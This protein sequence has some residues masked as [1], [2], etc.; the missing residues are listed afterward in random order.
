M[1]LVYNILASGK[2]QWW[3]S[4]FLGKRAAEEKRNCSDS[5]LEMKGKTTRFVMVSQSFC[6]MCVYV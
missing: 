2:R 4:G 1:S 6:V 5:F 3:D